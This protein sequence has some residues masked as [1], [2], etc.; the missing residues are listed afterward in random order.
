MEN[1]NKNNPGGEQQIPP[2]P[3]K[4][5]KVDPKMK[6]EQENTSDVGSGKDGSEKRE[7]TRS[8]MAI[9]FVLGFFAVLFLCFIYAIVA[10]AT[11]GELKD[12]LIGIAGALSGTLGFIVGFYYKS[13]LEK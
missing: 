3:D 2:Q 10:N 1:E 7:D 4:L 13:V 6:T 11:L 12:A 5:N 9:L 8:T